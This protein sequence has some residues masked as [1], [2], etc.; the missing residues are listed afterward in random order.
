MFHLQCCSHGNI[1]YKEASTPLAELKAR[2]VKVREALAANLPRPLAVSTELVGRECELAGE[3][4]RDYEPTG[5][6][7]MAA[8]KTLS[9]SMVVR[10]EIRATI[11]E[12]I[13]LLNRKIAILRIVW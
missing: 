10:K 8:I 4:A 3:A 11:A 12:A 6:D 5:R 1:S 13:D 9:R 7:I 2:A